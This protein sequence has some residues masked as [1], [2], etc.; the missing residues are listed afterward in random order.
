MRLYVSDGFS[1]GVLNEAPIAC[2]QFRER[3]I[4]SG[5][6]SERQHDFLYATKNQQAVSRTDDDGGAQISMAWIVVSW[7]CP[8]CR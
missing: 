2:A 4:A 1:A 7:M 3:T 6:W 5:S 8:R